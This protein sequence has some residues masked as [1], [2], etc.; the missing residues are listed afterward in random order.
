MPISQPPARRATTLRTA[1]AAAAMTLAARALIVRLML[2]K[3]QR[4]VDALNA[5]DYGP[6]LSNF[7]PDAVLRFNDGEHRWAGEHRGK[8]AVGRFLQDFVAAGIHGHIKGLLVAGPP[9]RM[10]L[11]VRFDDHAHD[12]AGREIYRNRT[13]LV[14]QARWGRIVLQEDFYEDTRRIE[15]L[16]SELQ[17][18]GVA[19]ASASPA[20]EPGLVA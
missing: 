9:W 19:P 17:K 16:E 15:A 13:A 11:A 7:A 14:A 10:T 18:L 5:G 8:A 6:I 12:P 3:L 1:G 2:A 20:P 4:D